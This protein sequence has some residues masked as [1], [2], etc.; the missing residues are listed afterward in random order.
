MGRESSTSFERSDDRSCPPNN[1][2]LVEQNKT[3]WNTLY[4]QLV[5]GA[6]TP[7]ACNGATSIDV[8]PKGIYVIILQAKP[9]SDKVCITCNMWSL[10]KLLCEF[11]SKRVDLPSMHGCRLQHLRN[12]WGVDFD[13]H[14]SYYHGAYH[15]LAFNWLVF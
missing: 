8:L 11:C 13:L 9:G 10:K 15:H 14:S 5:E 7:W 3:V 2:R 1:P 12:D 6:V 4:E